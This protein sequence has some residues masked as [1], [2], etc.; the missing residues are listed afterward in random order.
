MKCFTLTGDNRAQVIPIIG[1]YLRGLNCEKPQRVVVDD[2]KENRSRDQ[3]DRLWVMYK[4]I[5]D[6]LG[7]TKD[8]I[9][10]L[11]R[12]KHLGMQ[13]K[14]VAGEFIEYVPSTTK[15]KVGEMCAYQDEI[16]R[17]AG[18]YGIRLPAQEM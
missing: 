2:K 1:Q 13:T 18:Q 7:Y 9:H 6:E 12:Y 11:M 5:G 16:E 14:E 10:E 3:N 15:L 4:I 17:W 8:E